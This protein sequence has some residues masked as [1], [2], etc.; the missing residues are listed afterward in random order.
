M[1]QFPFTYDY[2]N[3]T[4]VQEK[5]V[6]FLERNQEISEQL[7]ELS[8]AFHSIGIVIPHTNES[9]WSGHY[10]P[11]SESFDEYQISYCL[12]SQ[13]FYKQAM[14]SLRSVLENG[15]LSVY[16]NINDEG[17]K[18]VQGWL[19]SL[20]GKENDTPYFKTIW[21]ILIAHPNIKKFQDIYNL[22]SEIENLNFLHNYVH[23]KGAIYSNQI[24]LLK[25][26]SQ[27]FEIS[28]FKSWLNAANSVIKVILILHLL[29]FPLGIV[30]Y[31][32]SKKFGVD[33]P[34]FGGL[35][36][37]HI[38]KIKAVIGSEISELLTNIAL[39][40][41]NVI[42]FIKRIDKMPDITQDQINKQIET[43]N[44]MTSSE[45]NTTEDD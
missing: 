14:V 22:K 20:E 27:T 43:I 19:Q 18:T 28:G 6:Q 39:K 33:I 34:T 15:L 2:K 10:F 12:C 8:W 31:D 3:L 9:W 32:Y 13:G 35:N 30:E 4:E 44:R 40:D 24:G 21:R 42:E 36:S 17:H 37:F 41:K 38:R 1:I 45:S 16:Y 7:H 5:T 25:L 23:S 11:Y 26:N 29:K